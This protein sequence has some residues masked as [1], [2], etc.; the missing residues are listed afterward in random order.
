M[1]NN[2]IIKLFLCV[3][4]FGMLG[5]SIILGAVGIDEIPHA[6]NDMMDTMPMPMIFLVAVVVAPVVEELLFRLHLKYKPLMFLFLLISTVTTVLLITGESFGDMIDPNSVFPD[7]KFRAPLI[8]LLTLSAASLLFFTYFLSKPFRAWIDK[9]LTKYFGIPFYATVAI[10]AFVHV[11]NFELPP[12][13]WY[14]GPL[15]VLPQLIIG[16]LLGYVRVR[17]SVFH[18]MLVHGMNNSIPMFIMIYMKYA[19]IEM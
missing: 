7:L 2:E 17:N 12:D 1:T 9:V 6:M 15:L 3:F 18:S 19:G 4:F 16:L 5:S 11:F 14:Y 13:M 8:P 10:F